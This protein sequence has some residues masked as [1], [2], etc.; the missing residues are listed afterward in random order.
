MLEYKGYHATIT[1][2]HEDDI[3]VGSIFGIQ[4]SINF[5]GSS[6]SEITEMFYQSVDNYLQY[7][8]E[9]GDV[10]GPEKL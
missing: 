4:D 3:L 1:Y 5:H 7:C 6:V 9:S 2:D 8:Q 10:L